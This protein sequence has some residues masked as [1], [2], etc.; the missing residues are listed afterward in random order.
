LSG[1]RKKMFV[2]GNEAVAL[3]SLAAGVKFFAGYPITPSTEI[4]EM[5]AEELPK[6][7]GKFIQME[8]EIASMA[9]IIGASMAGVKSMTA[10]SGPG[11]SLMQENIGLAS[12]LETPCAIVNVQRGGPST[13]LPTRTHSADMMQTKWGSHG[14]YAIIA[15]VAASVKECFDLTIKTV[16]LSERYRVPAVFLTEESIG[17]MRE[18]IEVPPSEE[19]ER[20][21]RAAP[22]VR[23][24]EFLPFDDSFG[25]VPPF[26]K[27]GVGY[28]YH[29][30]GLTHDK[31]GFPTSRPDEIEDLMLRF[32]RK[33][34]EDKPGLTEVESYRTEDADVL[35]F[36]YGSSA[37]AAKGAVNL[38]RKKGL[39]LGL[40]RPIV[41]WPF[42]RKVVAKAA[43]KVKH[44]IV[45]ELNL[46]QIVGEVERAAQG[47][48]MVHG[49]SKVSSELYSPTELLE[50]VERV[51][52]K[53]A[54]KA[55]AA[56]VAK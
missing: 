14:D 2:Q 19:V 35:F 22:T 55:I 15:V 7:G 53:K 49:V 17:H 39:K 28:R 29:V 5:L 50:H 41:I 56:S 8:D 38:A 33:V 3:G 34:T 21:D 40:L 24:E 31:S 6:V 37:R 52:K 11:F 26:I 48:A 47:M 4:A 27:F 13:G 16:N 18:N 51:L 43:A 54:W 10:T 12:M 45:P 36:A 20:V 44:I 9:A 1:R 30:T 42:P 32:R 46:G 23:P 25:D